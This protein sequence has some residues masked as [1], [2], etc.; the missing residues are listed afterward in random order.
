MP[1]P[2]K[3]EQAN[4]NIKIRKSSRDLLNSLRDHFKLDSQSDAIDEAY[5]KL[6]KTTVPLAR[7]N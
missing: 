2:R 6:L 7:R 3:A 1:R 4:T 5:R